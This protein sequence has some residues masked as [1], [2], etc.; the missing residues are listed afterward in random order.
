MRKLV[1]VL[2]ALAASVGIA[3]TAASSSADPGNGATVVNGLFC[4]V[5]LP[6]VSG[7]TTDS[8]TVVTPSGNTVVVCHFDIP[9]PTGKALVFKDFGCATLIG[10]TTDSQF[11]LSAG[12]QGTLTCHINGQ[13]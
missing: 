12:G 10:G 2:A 5:F 9:N 11:V 4:F 8:H 3:T 1:F 6:P 7:T 13:T